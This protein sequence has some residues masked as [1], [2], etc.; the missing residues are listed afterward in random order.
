MPPKPGEIYLLPSADPTFGDPKDGRPHILVSQ[1]SVDP[2]IATVV[3]CS[4]QT[5][6]I[7]RFAPPH[8]MID[9]SGSAFA[10]TGLHTT[11]VAYP[12]RLVLC[13]VSDLTQ[14][15]GVLTDEFGQLQSELLRAIGFRTGVSK[16]SDSQASGSFRGVVVRFKADFGTYLGA[17]FGVIV[18]NPTYS[19]R[20][21][22][23]NFVPVFSTGDLPAAD[24]V[25]EVEVEPLLTA[26][27]VQMLAAACLVQSIKQSDVS[28]VVGHVTAPSMRALEDALAV[29]FLES[30]VAAETVSL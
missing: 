13:D 7:S 3:Y 8:V 26:P 22:F 25:V 2:S 9:E 24:G 30:V 5:W 17:D 18:S 15:V 14:K 23:Q 11:T 20:A 29:R 28:D 1:I 27:P 12:G 6:E 4:T 16:S 19:R 10:L 21:L